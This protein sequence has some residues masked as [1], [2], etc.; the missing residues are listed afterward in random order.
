MLWLPFQSQ[1]QTAHPL[2]PVSLPSLTC[3]WVSSVLRRGL[4]SN[5]TACSPAPELFLPRFSQNL[6]QY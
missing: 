5:N 6:S 4:L 1:S 2:H 3:D